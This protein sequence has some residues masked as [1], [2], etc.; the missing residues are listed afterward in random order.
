MQIDTWQA[1]LGLLGSLGLGGVAKTLIDRRQK[2][3]EIKVSTEKMAIDLLMNQF[4]E[5]KQENERLRK[6][7]DEIKQREDEKDDQI[8]Q[9]RIQMMTFQYRNNSLN[10][11][12]WRKNKNLILTECNDKY[13]HNFLTPRG[14]QATDYIGQDDFSVW[15]KDVAEA[16]RKNDKRV[17]RTGKAWLGMEEV[18]TNGHFEDWLIVKIPDNDGTMGF[19]F[20]MS[21]LI[22]SDNLN[23]G[24]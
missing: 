6:E 23:V 16:Y 1:L 7:I 2:K 9:L 18:Q 15:S 14:Y 8:T 12:F 19:A 3:D 13:V 4:Q 24:K 21:E 22:I 10:V 11:A 5:L 17:M 20:A